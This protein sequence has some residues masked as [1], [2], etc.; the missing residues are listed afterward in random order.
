MCLL[1]CNVI[2]SVI[3]CNL[4]LPTSPKFLFFQGGADCWRPKWCDSYLGSKDRP[5][6]TADPRARGLSQLGPHRPR[7]QL[8][9]RSQQ[10]GELHNTILRV[11]LY[12]F[13]VN[14]KLIE[15]SF[16]FP[17]PLLYQGNCYVWNLAG[18]IGEEV[19]QMIPKTKIPA[20]NRYSLRCKFS[21]DS[22]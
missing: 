5:Q 21:P 6:R 15:T 9:G 12:F 4:M 14:S 22:T 17:W 1:V 11:I 13:I 10:L 8:H 18:G 2:N 7:C 20:H 3:S 16:F 19:T